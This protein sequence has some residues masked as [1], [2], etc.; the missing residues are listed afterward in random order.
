MK[1]VLLIFVAICLFFSTAH[2]ENG[3]ERVYLALG[4][5]ITSGFGLKDGE[6][7]FAEILAA[8]FG[9]TLIN[10]GV[11][12]YTAVS[13]VRSLGDSELLKSIRKAEVITITCGGNDL[14]ALLF[15]KAANVYN[16]HYAGEG[17]QIGALEIYSIMMAGNDPRATKILECAQIVFEGREEWGVTPFLESPEINMAIGMFNASLNMF[18]RIIK[19]LNP[20]A[21]V[22]VSTQYNPY[23]NFYGELEMLSRNVDLGAQ[24]LNA[25]IIE[26][27]QKAGYL[28]ADVYTAF[29]AA[30]EN[31]LNAIMEPWNVDFH[32]NAVG[33]RVISHCFEEILRSVGK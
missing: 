13:L 7:C 9:Y 1:R 20:D 5:S 23:R 29:D 19:L 26:N 31:L 30:Q 2:A 12:G 22:V 4:D 28:V 11:E 32:P 24:M 21:A 27:A 17:E 8:E 6:L 14:I 15:L 16:K 33:H 25:S 3:A 18:V 10:E